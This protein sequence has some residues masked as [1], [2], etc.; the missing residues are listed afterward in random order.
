[1]QPIMLD[2]GHD[3]IIHKPTIE[4]TLYALLYTTSLMPT[5]AI[6]TLHVKQGHLQIL[7]L[8]LEPER[9]LLRITV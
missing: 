3:V 2:P 6:L 1:M 5:W 4:S 8:I 7:S 9:I